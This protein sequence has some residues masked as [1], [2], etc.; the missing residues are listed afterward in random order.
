MV[1]RACLCIFTTGVLASACGGGVTSTPTSATGGSAPAAICRNYVTQM[2]SQYTSTGSLI[3]SSTACQ[4]NQSTAEYTCV[5]SPQ[6]VNGCSITRTRADRYRSV[7]DFAASGVLVGRNST[8]AI[9]ISDI[10][11]G[12]PSCVSP[13]TVQVTYSYDSQGRVTGNAHAAPGLGTFFTVSYTSWDG[14]GRPTAGTTM[15]ANPPTS[16]PPRSLTNQYDDANRIITGIYVGSNSCGGS[17]TVVERYDAN[18]NLIE[19]RTEGQTYSYTIVGTQQVC[20]A[21]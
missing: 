19:R 15:L 3:S 1:C 8:Q 18:F 6:V 2:N 21:R 13:P 9:T 14:A 16:C 20:S 7:A 12:G 5:T 4:L 17:D 10:S 11:A